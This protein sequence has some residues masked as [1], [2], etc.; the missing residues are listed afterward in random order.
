MNHIEHTLEIEIAAPPARVWKAL[1]DQIG[2]W[3]HPG[4]VTRKDAIAFIL[5]PRVGGR[6]YEDWGDGQGLLWYTVISIARNEHLQLM[7]DL[8]ARYGGPA[9]LHTAFRLRAEGKGTVLR[10]EEQA[11]GTVGEKTK[12]SLE[13]GWK[14]LLAGCLKVFVETGKPPPE[15]PAM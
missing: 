13:E 14:I 5:E 9:R 10:L 15:W 11:F 4:F 3:W 6:M 1:T 12:R 7:G 2:S 8:D